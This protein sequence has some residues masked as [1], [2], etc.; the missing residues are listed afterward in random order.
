MNHKLMEGYM[1]KHLSA[2]SVGTY[3]RCAYQ[4][5]LR[6]IEDIIIPP[7]IAMLKGGSAHKGN[8]HTNRTLM[9]KQKLPPL[10]EVQDITRDSFVS[11]SIENG[12]WLL[13]EEK[14]AKVS[15]L[16]DGLNESIDHASSY[17]ST[18]ASKIKDIS[19]VEKFLKADIGL[20]LPIVGIPDFIADNN[21]VDVKISGK[22][23]AENAEHKAIQPTFYK[24]LAREN[25][26][27]EM[28]KYKSAFLVQTQYKTQPKTEPYLWDSERRIAFDYR[29]TNR[30]EEDEKCLMNILEMIIKSIQAG[31]FMPADPDHWICSR[32]RCGYFSRCPY[33]RWK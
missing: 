32:D 20:D 5:Y 27:I 8:E 7:N 33:V 31:T 2:S 15:L 26:L 29:V 30:T 10:D 6:Y 14:S 21:N 19:L 9:E 28:E 3:L 17:H 23:M 1:I 11:R 16:N 18:Y 12:I 4:F 22:R 13:D 25:K 24:I